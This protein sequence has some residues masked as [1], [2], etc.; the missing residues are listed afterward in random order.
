MPKGIFLALANPVSDDVEADFNTWYDASH[1]REVL[2]LPGVNSCTRYVLADGQLMPGDDA[3]GYRYLALYEVDV[4]DWADFSKAMQEG[5]A[6]G[7]I[8]IDANLLS[9]DPM[10]KTIV[11]EQLGQ[12]DARLS[13]MRIGI[14]VSDT[15]G[16]RTGVEEML[17]RA[18]VGRR[19]RVHERR[20]FRRSRGALTR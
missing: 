10:V 2:A 8:T 18:Q 20:G 3:M 11:F 19:E 17:R 6:E 15:G 7:T 9:M 12:H 4:D 16:E 14:F 13:A 1:A 5:F